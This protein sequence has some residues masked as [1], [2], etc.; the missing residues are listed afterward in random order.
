MLRE[1]F[2]YRVTVPIKKAGAY[3]LRISLRDSVSD[4]VGS[5]S[6]FVEAPDIRKNRL[7][8]SG[9]V[10]RGEAPTAS[11][12]TSTGVGEGV[13]SGSAEAS[14]AVRHFK[15]GMVMTYGLFIYNARIDK[16]TAHP[17]LVTQ[18]RLFRDG[19]EIFEGKKTP[20]DRGQQTDMKRLAA[21]GGL[22]L[23]TEMSPGE[24]ILQ[25]IV[26]DLLADKKYQSVTQSIDFQIV[27]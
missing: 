22:F 19:K 3:Q 17:Q 21:T 26:T 1:G 27:D 23:G 14:P 15:R 7:A 5:A 8:L 4:R 6:Q 9:I 12:T 24:Y 20:Y 13:D 2:V 11:A 16:A 25:V 10:I 18:V